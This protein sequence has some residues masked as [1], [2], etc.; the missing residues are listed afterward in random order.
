M[1]Y[2]LIIPV[3]YP[4]ILKESSDQIR[5]QAINHSGL[6]PVLLSNQKIPME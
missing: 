3:I 5:L 6:L 1:N 4:V 2:E